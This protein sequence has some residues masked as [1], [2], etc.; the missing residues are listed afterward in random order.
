M[1]IAGGGECIA[2]KMA[3]FWMS[4]AAMVAGLKVASIG[5]GL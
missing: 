2:A 5:E 1:E 4:V 3:G